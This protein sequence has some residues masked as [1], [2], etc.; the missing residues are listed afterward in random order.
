MF[1]LHL[2]SWLMPK[3][4]LISRLF[5]ILN[6]CAEFHLKSRARKADRHRPSVRSPHSCRSWP[7]RV[8]PGHPPSMV[9]RSGWQ[10]HAAVT[11]QGYRPAAGDLAKGRVGKSLGCLNLIPQ[12]FPRKTGRSQADEESSSSVHTKA[13]GIQGRPQGNPAVVCPF[14]KHSSCP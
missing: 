6:L 1:I 7:F 14:E 11:A 3:A 2:M 9:L 5:W 10:G 8:R 4:G 12:P 13:E